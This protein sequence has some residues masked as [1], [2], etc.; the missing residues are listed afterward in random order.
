MNGRVGQLVHSAHSEQ[1]RASGMKNTGLAGV[2]VLISSL[3]MMVA[4]M[5]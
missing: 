4:F 2:A 1:A 5:S 3:I